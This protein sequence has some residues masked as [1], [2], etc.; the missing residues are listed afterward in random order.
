MAKVGWAHTRTGSLGLSTVTLTWAQ[1]Q[2][3]PHSGLA[4]PTGTGHHVANDGFSSL[5]WAYRLWDT[6]GSIEVWTSP[7]MHGHGGTR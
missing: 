3:L 1:L 4:L 6:V 7:Q 2:F 5:R